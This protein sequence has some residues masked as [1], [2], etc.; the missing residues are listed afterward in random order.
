MN[1]NTL[2]ALAGA[3]A[4]NPEKVVVDP[5]PVVETLLMIG[6]SPSVWKLT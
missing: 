5:S 6:V 3:D 1:T 4:K 2:A